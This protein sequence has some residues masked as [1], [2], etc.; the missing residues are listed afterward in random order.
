MVRN[1]IIQLARTSE[2]SITEWNTYKW[3]YWIADVSVTTAKYITNLT[4]LV[5]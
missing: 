1:Q 4:E 5:G 3:V 2:L